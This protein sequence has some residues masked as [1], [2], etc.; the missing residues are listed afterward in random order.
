MN[1]NLSTQRFV[2]IIATA[3]LAVVLYSKGAAAD[4]ITVVNGDF[5]TIPASGF[6][7]LGAA[8]GGPGAIP[9]WTTTVCCGTVVGQPIGD[10]C[11]R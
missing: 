10:R 2:A 6:T 3:A 4:Q 5:Q 9:G 11:R 7:V 8:T 1:S